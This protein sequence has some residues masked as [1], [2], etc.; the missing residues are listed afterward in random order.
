VSA[1]KVK[2]IET[3]FSASLFYKAYVVSEWVLWY[4]AIRCFLIAS[5]SELIYLAIFLASVLGD[6]E[7]SR[8]GSSLQRW[9]IALDFISIAPQCEP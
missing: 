8:I 7:C 6:S 2:A 5:L 1:V 4:S 9:L 3:Q